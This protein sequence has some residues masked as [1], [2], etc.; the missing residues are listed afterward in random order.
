MSGSASNSSV[1][2]H[3]PGCSRMRAECCLPTRPAP[4]AG[5]SQLLCVAALHSAA[6]NVQASASLQMRLL[7]DITRARWKPQPASNGR[8]SERKW[9][10]VMARRAVAAQAAGARQ[11]PSWSSDSGSRSCG[12]SGASKPRDVQSASIHYKEAGSRADSHLLGR[13]R[14]NRWPA[15]AKSCWPNQ[16][17]SAAPREVHH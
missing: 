3:C 1:P 12:G 8:V 11:H 13:T 4:A 16:P 17:S 7:Q 15:L 14:I 6:A 2:P 9:A 5:S 10:G